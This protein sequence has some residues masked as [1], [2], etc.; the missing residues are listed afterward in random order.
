MIE[1]LSTALTADFGKGFSYANL[2]NFRQFYLIFPDQSILYTTCRDLSWSHLRLIMRVDS[3]QAIDYY[4]RE[5]REQG[6]TVRQLE[7]NIKS[8][9]FQRLLSSQAHSPSTQGASDHLDFIKDPYVLEFLQLPEA[10]QVKESRLE[11]AIIDELQKFLLELGK[12]FSFVAR[13]MRISTETS[14]FFIDLVFYN[15]LLKCFVILDLKTDKLSHQDIGQMDMYVRMFDDLKRGEDD[16]PTI[17]IIL[18]DSKDETI[19]KYSVIQENQ[20][21][22]ASKYQ[23][24]LPT[25][26]ELIAEIEREKRLIENSRSN[27]LRGGVTH[28][29]DIVSP[30]GEDWDAEK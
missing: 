1:E 29:Q 28:E 17:G 15:Y 8:Q 20:Q 18:C 14:H 10:G 25:E 22:F 2:Y 7:R 3:P 12:G 21:L 9:S 11:Q 4:C 19:V 27:P 26:E 5:A 30:D 13:Q 6:W 23:R 24:I 16:N